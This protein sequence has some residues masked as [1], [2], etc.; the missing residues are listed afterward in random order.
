MA[1]GT[2]VFK[3]VGESA[4]KDAAAAAAK[5]AAKAAADDAAKAAAKDAAEAAGK[6]AAEDAAKAAAEDA[7]KAAAKDAAEASAKDAAK[8][9]GKDVSKMS[10]KDAA[11][12]A[13]GAAALGLG[14]YTYMNASD[15]A[16]KSNSTP[17]GITKIEAATGTAIKITFTPAIRVV[18][19]DQLT[20]SGTKT[21]PTLD[22]SATPTT[23]LSDGQIVIDPGTKLTDM[24]VG[25]TINVKT[26]PGNQATDSLA[27]AATLTGDTVVDTTGGMF[28][29]LFDTLGLGDYATYIKWGCGVLCLLLIIGTITYFV[30][31]N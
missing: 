19:G 16:D 29:K 25:G 4:A 23:I 3:D 1:I 17:R 7:A 21:T 14:V 30:M 9:A 27:Q 2:A 24:T 12:Y 31:K 8:A 26:T 10:A 20:I 22:G 6:T 18:L 11:K 13:A 15:A 28:D 5:D